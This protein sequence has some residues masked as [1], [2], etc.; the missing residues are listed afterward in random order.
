MYIDLLPH[1]ISWD[2]WTLEISFFACAS[3]AVLLLPVEKNSETSE[4]N[5]LDLYYLIESSAYNAYIIYYIS[6]HI[7]TL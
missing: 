3:L 2:I 1:Q 7:R 4:Y 5:V 6:Q